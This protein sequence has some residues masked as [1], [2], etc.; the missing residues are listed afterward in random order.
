MASEHKK[1]NFI[2]I[3]S[4]ISNTQG[5]NLIVCPIYKRYVDDQLIIGVILKKGVD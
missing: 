4:I 3:H 1:D 2:N 5:E